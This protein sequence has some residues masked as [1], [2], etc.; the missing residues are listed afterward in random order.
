MPN[1]VSTKI[2]CKV[3]SVKEF[4]EIQNFVKGEETDFDFDKIIPMPKTL[5]LTEGSITDNAILHIFLLKKNTDRIKE[6]K[7]ALKKVPSLLYGNKMIEIFSHAKNNQNY[8]KNIVN[9]AN[10]YIPSDE[11]KELGIKTLEDLGNMYI[12]NAIKYGCL[13]W[14]D[15]AYNNWGTKWNACKVSIDKDSTEFYFETAWSVATPIIE[16][17]SKIF[18]NVEFKVEYADEDLGQNCGIFIVK[19]GEVI[20]QVDMGNGG[21]ASKEFA[22]KLRGYSDEEIKEYW[23]E[24]ERDDD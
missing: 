2:K 7:D 17:L 20:H 11:E 18:P 12:D 15:W 8:L 22:M 23:K 6:I 9:N 4:E 14:Y 1:W 24:M 21:N 5:K 13:T 10:T 3:K 16:Q 19:D